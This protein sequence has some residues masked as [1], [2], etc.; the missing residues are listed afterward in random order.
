M[1]NLTPLQGGVPITVGGK[2]VGAIGVSG[3][4]SAAQDDEIASSGASEFERSHQAKTDIAHE[5]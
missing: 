5:E 3:A 2:V 4:S 1:R